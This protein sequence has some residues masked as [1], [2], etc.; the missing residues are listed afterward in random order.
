MAF[1]AIFGEFLKMENLREE[2]IFQLQLGRVANWKVVEET[3]M[4]EDLI[5]FM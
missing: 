4:L 2:R 5:V 1:T 3:D